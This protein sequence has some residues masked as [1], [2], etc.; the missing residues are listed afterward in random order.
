MSE[1]KAVGTPDVRMAI[2][3][4]SQATGVDFKYL[5]AQARLESGLDPQARAPT[6]SAAGLYQFIGSTWLE[7]LD[8]HGDRHGL[9]WAGNAI[10]NKGSRASITD[11]ALRSQIMSLRYDADASSLMAAELAR[12]NQ[13]ALRGTLRREPDSAELY[14][15]HFMGQDGAT[16]FLTALQQNPGQSAASLFPKPASANRTIFFED[17]GSPRSM[18][19]V[20]TLLRDK[21]QRA[22][23]Q[24][25]NVYIPG[26]AFAESFDTAAASFANPPAAIPLPAPARALGPVAREFQEVAANHPSPRLS[27][28]E[29]LRTAFAGAG[30]ATGSQP[31]ALPD[32]VRSAYTKLKA[33]GL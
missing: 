32:S 22:M 14:L 23:A 13:E 29:T 5:L 2:A 11:P 9:G 15:A 10:A 28:A 27:M 20:M 25:G 33:Y 6:S 30:S 26:G 3:R 4:A 18:G 31:A 16:K 17:D 1:V 7:T 8:R 24:D 12:D 19:Q 21:V